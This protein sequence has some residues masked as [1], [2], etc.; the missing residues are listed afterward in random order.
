[1][2]GIKL[3]GMAVLLALFLRIFCFS[4]YK[5]PSYSMLPTITGGDYILVNKWILGPR[6]Y[7]SFDF[8]NDQKIETYRLKGLRKVKRNDVLV[9]NFP[10]GEDWNTMKFNRKAY[11]LKRCVAIPGDTFYIERGIYKVKNI[12]D[13]LGCY[14]NQS[15]NWKRFNKENSDPVDES[16]PFD[17]AYNWTVLDFGPL[18]IPKKDKQIA[19]D[20]LNIKLY[21][22]L[23]SYETGKNITIKNEKV[24]LDKQILSNY[25]FQMNYYFMTGDYVFDSCDSRYWGLVPEDHIVGKA[26]IIRQ[27]KDPET[28][29]FR[30]D[31]FLKEIK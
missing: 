29:K 26:I 22:N 30:W 17:R 16:F 21:R 1:M 24:Y 3:I 20:T 4:S 18:Y 28:K 23:I 13:T 2:F 31:R 5:I 10:Y 9:F 19:I 7:K 14:Q 15:D 27:S 25:T 12:S 11:Y 8:S 6:L